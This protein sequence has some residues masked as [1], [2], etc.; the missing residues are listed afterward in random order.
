MNNYARWAACLNTETP[1]NRIILLAIAS[2]LM[3]GAVI[4]AQ[5]VSWV[6]APVKTSPSERFSA[7]MAFDWKTRTTLLFGGAINNGQKFDDTWIWH[8]GWFQLSP[9]TSPP[10]RQGPGMVWD[11]A[12][13]N[14]VL[15]GGLD[16][17]GV[18]LN[19]TWLWNGTNW[20]EQ[21]PPISPPG[22]LFDGEGMTYDAA[23]HRV[24]LFGG[25]NGVN[26]VLGDTW[27]WDGITKTWT[28]HFPS[29]SP[30]SRRTVL[31]YDYASK[32]VVLFGGDNGVVHYGDTWTWDGVNWTQKFPLTS[33]SPRTMGSFAWDDRLGLLVLFGGSGAGAAELNDTWI[34]KDSTWTQ[35]FPTGSTPPGRWAAPIDYDPVSRGLLLFGGCCSYL[36]DTWLFFYIP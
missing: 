27:T 21:Y 18:F 6:Q 13:G 20:I 17:N 4:R 16:A 9:A 19:D 28:Q 12:S 3:G 23:T 5:S 25:T 1:Y 35:V 22:R 32:N 26:V 7:G 30:S 29:T 11:A 2:V 24:L 36:D 8:N 31:A 34:W 10:A 15:F 33:P 14:I